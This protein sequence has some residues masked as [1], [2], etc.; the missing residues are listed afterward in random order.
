MG[1]FLTIAFAIGLFAIVLY[2]VLTKLVYICGPNEVLVFSGGRYL[3][4]SGQ[5]VGY[6]IVKGGR[7][8]RTPFLEE[9][10]RLD[11]TN[12][13]IEVGVRGAFSRG[14]IP[15]NIDGIANVKISGVSPGLDNALQRL[16]GKPRPLVMKI[17]KETLEGYLRGVLAT[18]TPEEVNEDTQAFERE[19]RKQ[20]GEGF[21]TLGLTLDNLKIQ[22]VND[23]Q[24]YLTAMGRIR[25]AELNRD[26]RTAEAERRCESLVQQAEARRKGELAKIQAELDILEAETERR[27]R[28]AQTARGAWVAQEEGEVAA[29]L[30][31]AK[32]ELDLQ[33]ARIEQ[34]KH[35]L[36]AE[37]V[38]PA[39]AKMEATV[40]KAR[41]EAAPILEHGRAQA[42]ALRKL[43]EQ[44][45]ASGDAAKDI[46]L[47]Q[48]LE[49]ILPT[50]LQSID[51]VRVDNV[52]M[53]Q[54][55]GDGG[56]LPAQAVATVK[57]L[58]A[59]GI[60]VPG[61]L[62]RLTGGSGQPKAKRRTTVGLEPP[63]ADKG[64]SKGQSAR[65]ED[66]RLAQA[67]RKAPPA[68]TAAPA[69]APT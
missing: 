6:R 24:G 69:P 38:T 46:F 32:A 31:R 40:E 8:L 43:A 42:E 41:G 22:A 35:Q 12:M 29:L 65:A 63:R 59:G 66:S 28:N 14:G 25:A 3:S 52:T 37:V 58:E 39:R 20:A 23:D 17:A 49:T 53:L 21:D 64:K 55:T 15:L 26:N 50:F 54:G 57:A 13:N 45:H 16:L 67:V 60:D 51:R 18:L 48:K 27:V 7:A 2:F 10:S 34:M 47:L 9:V 11:L 56:G 4:K 30:T 61:I 44:W 33:Q 1:I 36:N 5:Q 68:P 19:L 62:D